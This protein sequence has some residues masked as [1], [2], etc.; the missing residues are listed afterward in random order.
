M[1]ETI[2]TDVAKKGGIEKVIRDGEITGP[3]VGYPCKKGG[4]VNF[5][6]HYDKLESRS[7]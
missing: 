6:G 4:I 7:D 3:A 2:V 1:E 5:D